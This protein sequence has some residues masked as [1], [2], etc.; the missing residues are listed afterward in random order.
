MGLLKKLAELV[1]EFPEDEPGQ[2]GAGGKPG[3]RGA[4]G[5]GPS[6]RGGGA[7]GKPA[8]GGKPG[9]G[10]VVDAIERI[11]LDLE[12][13]L[14]PDFSDPGAKTAPASSSTAPVGTAP[15][16]RP[17]EGAAA[18]VSP[19]A[20]GIDP[21]DIA[22][23]AQGEIV[24]LPGVL[25]VTGVYERAQLTGQDFDIYKVETLMADKEVADLEPGMRARMVRMTLKNLGKELPD[26]LA[27]AGR[28]DAVLEAYARLLVQQ[29]SQL[30]AEVERINAAVQQEI[31]AF[32]QART[33][34]IKANQQR[35]AEYEAKVQA[36]KEAKHAEEERLFNIAAPFVEHG[37]NP[38]DVE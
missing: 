35:L 22:G 7:T 17:G 2:P 31:D 36:F 37:A 23:A 27:D 8:G 5:H 9:G 11:R 3:A 33:A 4:G 20:T 12:Q 19:T 30:G 34:V 24:A 21:A 25:D 6:Q 28:R 1:I 38:V 26:I 18:N 13:S 15:A 32:M 16:A 10:D 14:A 29:G